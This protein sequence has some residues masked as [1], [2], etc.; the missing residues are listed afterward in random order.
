MTK[1]KELFFVEKK[2]V[3]LEEPRKETVLKPTYLQ[4]TFLYASEPD[5]LW[6]IRQHFPPTIKFP[7]KAE[8]TQNC[9]LYAYSEK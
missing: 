1:K 2:T 5:F 8:P 3:F 9:L 7:Q 4:I 6:M